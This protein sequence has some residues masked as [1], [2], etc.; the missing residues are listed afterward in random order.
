MKLKQLFLIMLFAIPAVGQTKNYQIY[1]SLFW[2]CI[3]DTIGSL[4][5]FI[6]SVD[7]ILK[8]PIFDQQ[9][10]INLCERLLQEVQR[11]SGFSYAPYTDDTRMSLLACKALIDTAEDDNEKKVIEIARI[12]WEDSLDFKKGWIANYRAPGL[13]TI[14]AIQNLPSFK[15]QNLINLDQILLPELK[16]Q[17]SNDDKVGGGCGS[18]M[19]AAPIGY[20]P[21]SCQQV[22]RLSGLH[23]KITHNH[24]LAIA[25]CAALSAAIWKMIH[26]HASKQEVIEAIIT[27]ADLVEREAFR[28]SGSTFPYDFRIKRVLELAVSSAE[29]MS[30]IRKKTNLHKNE[31]A[32]SFHD[33]LQNEQFYNTHCAMFVKI[34]PDKQ[35]FYDPIF[36]GWDAIT[37]LA[38]ALYNFCLFI[39]E[40]INELSKDEQVQYLTNALASAIITGGDS[41]SI[42][43]VTGALCGAF[44]TQNIVPQQLISYLEDHHMMSYYAEAISN[45]TVS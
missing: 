24:P 25:S 39:P 20:F 10:D 3:G 36:P 40:N 8:H 1:N 13:S 16:I 43:S 6:P 30:D 14:K 35:Y 4:T 18:V 41:D 9:F 15:H 45:L 2:G 22:I 29:H 38:A 11:L 33:L 31:Y 37:C 44:A 5:E 42:A 28:L 23:S 12:F 19:H 27:I 32:I 34:C 17:N 7:E 26:E 21:L